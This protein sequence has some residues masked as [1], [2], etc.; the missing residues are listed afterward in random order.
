MPEVNAHVDERLRT[1]PI[2]WL[3]TV[4]ADGRP[5]TVPVW[6]SWDGKAILVFSQP[7]TQKMRNL[8]HN[9]NVTLALDGTNGGEDVVVVEGKAELLKDS[10]QSMATPE[11][12][13][14]YTSFIQDMQTTPE[15]IGADYSEVIRVTPTKFIAWGGGS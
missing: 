12:L 6:F 7:G 5:H 15:E 3:T 8:Q 14:K 10:S 2:I 4:R 9:A 1:E 11:F 13:K